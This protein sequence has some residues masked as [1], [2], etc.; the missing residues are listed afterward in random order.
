MPLPLVGTAAPDFTLPSTSGANVTLSGFRGSQHVLL[1][2]FPAAF[3]SVCTAE[4]CSISED[5]AQF[6]SADTVVL[7]IS[8]DWI[9]ALKAFK[10]HTS[11]TIDLLSDAKREVSRAY[12]VYLEEAFVSKRAYVLIDK[13]GMVR[14]AFAEAELGQYRKST[15]LLE[16]LA[17]LA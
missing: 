10:A 9:P 17:A 7:P 12:G 4:L 2:F 6:G 13:T 8:I 14:W 11:M 15:E 3:S 16:Q 1:A 5:Y